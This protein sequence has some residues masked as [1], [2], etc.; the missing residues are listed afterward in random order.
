MGMAP[1]RR[2]VTLVS[3]YPIQGPKVWRS[4]S[5]GQAFCVLRRQAWRLNT[6]LIYKAFSFIIRCA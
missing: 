5:I 4:I 3:P 6:I 2:G 1:I